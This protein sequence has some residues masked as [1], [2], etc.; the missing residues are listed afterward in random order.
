MA[1]K[2]EGRHVCKCECGGEVRGIAPDV[3]GDLSSEAFVRKQR[4]EWPDRQSTPSEAFVAGDGVRESL[5]H[6]DEDREFAADL[7]GDLDIKAVGPQLEITT[8]WLCK[9]RVETARRL[10]A[11][12]APEPK[13]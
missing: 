2:R 7:L 4:S 8:Q 12:Q 1:K 13:K 5:H 10:S 9:H 3:T 11:L 6:T